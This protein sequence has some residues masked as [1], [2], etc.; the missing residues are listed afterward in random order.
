[1]ILSKE[2]ITHALTA[3]QIK[4]I[5]ENKGHMKQKD[6]ALAIG[7]TPACVN[8]RISRGVVVEGLFNVEEYAMQAYK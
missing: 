4:F 5:D 1:M 8:K 7:V 6:I 3:A 2:R